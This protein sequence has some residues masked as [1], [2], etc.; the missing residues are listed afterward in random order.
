MTESCRSGA[1]NVLHIHGENDSRVPVEGRR[2]IRFFVQNRP[3]RSV[4]QTK[5]ILEEAGARVKVIIIKDAGH[6]IREI[7]SYMKEQKSVGIPGIIARFINDKR[8]AAK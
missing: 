8:I 1:V 6:N 3:F 2:W 4:R 5:R 7:N